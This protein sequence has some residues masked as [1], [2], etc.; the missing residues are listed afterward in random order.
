MVMPYKRVETN[1]PVA[2]LSL[3][4]FMYKVKIAAFTRRDKVSATVSVRKPCSLSMK[5]MVSL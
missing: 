1:I 5:L 2:V 3:W 4:V